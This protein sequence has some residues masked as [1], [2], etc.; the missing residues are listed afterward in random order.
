[1]VV[2]LI[3]LKKMLHRQLKALSHHLSLKML[4]GRLP[5]APRQYW[6]LHLKGQLSTPSSCFK[7]RKKWQRKTQE[8]LIKTVIMKL[9]LL[10]HSKFSLQSKKSNMVL[11]FH[12]KRQETQITNTKKT[13]IYLT[14]K[15]YT[16]LS[17]NTSRKEKPASQSRISR[18]LPSKT[19]LILPVLAQESLKTS[20]TIRDRFLFVSFLSL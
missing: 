3:C 10:S 5:P 13:L 16:N 12:A 14:T 6:E 15:F 2:H 9:L 4:L 1:M 11:S 7:L 17:G 19:V 18:Y 20:W 8:Q